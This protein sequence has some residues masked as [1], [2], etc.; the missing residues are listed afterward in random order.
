MNKTTAEKN[1]IL[2][3]SGEQCQFQSFSIDRQCYVFSILVHD[4]FVYAS[5]NGQP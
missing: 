5:L 2:K 4:G 1:H 3:L